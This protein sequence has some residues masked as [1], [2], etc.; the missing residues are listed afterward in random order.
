[1]TTPQSRNPHDRERLPGGSSG[2]S[3]IAVATGMG[4][5]SLGTDTR[6]SVRVPAAL[7]G[8]VGFKPTYGHISTGEVVP[9]SWTMDHVGVLARTV[10]DAALLADVCR[11][12]GAS[13]ARAAGAPVAGL[14]VGVCEAAFDGADARVHA[15]VTA[16]IEHLGALGLEIV[17]SP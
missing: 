13:V 7:C 3:A 5:A 9:L 15:E 11:T 1:M 16:A 17:T 10:A 2:G 6:A 12:A 4:F 14:R 8:V